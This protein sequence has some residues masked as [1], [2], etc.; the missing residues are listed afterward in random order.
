MKAGERVGNFTAAEDGSYLFN[1]SDSEPIRKLPRLSWRVDLGD[2][3]QMVGVSWGRHFQSMNSAG[4][5]IL[6]TN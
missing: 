1:P 2:D 5:A 4:W 6:K 3:T